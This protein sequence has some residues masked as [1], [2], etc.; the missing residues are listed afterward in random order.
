M[1]CIDDT[2]PSNSDRKR[3]YELSREHASYL[4]QVKSGHLPLNIYLR[5]I[6]K[7]DSKLCQAYLIK[8]GERGRKDQAFH[9]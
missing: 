5:R 4:I 1:E 3:Q 9:L 8:Q 6:K 7:A 2:F